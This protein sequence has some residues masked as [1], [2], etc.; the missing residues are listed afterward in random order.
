MLE[1]IFDRTTGSDNSVTS[2]VGLLPKDGKF[3]FRDHIDSSA[4]PVRT[5][6]MGSRGPPGKAPI[7]TR[8]RHD[9]VRL[10]ITLGRDAWGP[11]R[12]ECFLIG[13]CTLP[14]T[15]GPEG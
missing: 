7:Y 1:W 12:A 8:T 11:D 5:L 14:Y 2:P 6:P 15:T 9:N 3:Y 4:A 10:D 13:L